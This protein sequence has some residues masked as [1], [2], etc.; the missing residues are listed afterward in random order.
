VAAEETNNRN[1]TNKNIIVSS[2]LPLL[3]G[4]CIGLKEYIIKPLMYTIILFLYVN[5]ISILCIKIIK[6]KL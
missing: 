3:P 1:S 5:L 6:I 4:A 2:A